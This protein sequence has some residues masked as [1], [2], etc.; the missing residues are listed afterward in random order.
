MSAKISGH[1]VAESGQAQEA[2]ELTDDEKRSI[3]QQSAVPGVSVAQVAR[4]Y[5]KN[6]NMIFS[7]FE[8][9]CFAPM[10]VAVE[11]ASARPR[12]ILSPGSPPRRQR[13][14]QKTRGSAIGPASRH[15]FRRSPCYARPQDHQSHH[16]GEVR[17]APRQRVARH[18][19][20]DR[21]QT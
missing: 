5:A 9:P 13:W 19:Q 11:D 10:P 18:S 20:L 16:R 7:W 12:M 6:A 4:R 8:G 21:S 2:A 1:Q 15:L 14:S 3:C 17:E